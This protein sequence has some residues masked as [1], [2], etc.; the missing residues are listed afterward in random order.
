MG[1]LLVCTA[2]YQMMEDGMVLMVVLELARAVY[3]ERE[4]DMATRT[5]SN[6]TKAQVAFMWG[7]VSSC[8]LADVVCDMAARGF[9]THVTRVLCTA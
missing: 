8:T 9:I 7:V 4:V 2:E 1:D 6:L 5:I 3:K